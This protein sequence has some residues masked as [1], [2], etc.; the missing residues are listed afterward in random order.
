M[1]LGFYPNNRVGNP[2]KVYAAGEEFERIKKFY[3]ELFDLKPVV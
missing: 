1:I 3:E 2:S